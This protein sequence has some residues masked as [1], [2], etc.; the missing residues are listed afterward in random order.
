MTDAAGNRRRS[1]AR[2]LI[3]RPQFRRQRRQLVGE[4]AEATLADSPLGALERFAETPI[5]KRLE[6]V[7][8]GATS[9]ASGA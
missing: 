8:A 6:D 3:V 1:S 7:V 5:G 9:N 2:W 4:L